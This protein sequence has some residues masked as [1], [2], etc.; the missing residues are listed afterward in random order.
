M[1]ASRVSWKKGIWSHLEDNL[2][3]LKN[4][5]GNLDKFFK[6]GVTF[7]QKSTFE[8]GKWNGALG[9]SGII[10]LESLWDDMAQPMNRIKYSMT[11]RE[12]SKRVRS[13]ILQ[14]QIDLQTYWFPSSS[15]VHGSMTWRILM[16]ASKTT[17]AWILRSSELDWEWA[18]RGMQDLTGN[19]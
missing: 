8:K 18:E 10:R 12:T 13:Q 1:D 15:K 4:V 17:P 9:R 2:E 14:Y 6:N 19:A 16:M 3:V 11:P 7:L 5:L